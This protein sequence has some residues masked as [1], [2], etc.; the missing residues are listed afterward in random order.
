MNATKIVEILEDFVRVNNDEK[1]ITFD[2]V[3]GIGKTYALEKW[4]KSLVNV[5]H[6]VMNVTKLFIFHY[7]G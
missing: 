3:W 7:L 4:L 6:L 5:K 2:G 1:C